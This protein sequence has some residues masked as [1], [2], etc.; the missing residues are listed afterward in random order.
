MRDN[1]K[2][3]A[4]AKSFQKMS[5][6]GAME[7][8]AGLTKNISNRIADISLDRDREK[9]VIYGSDSGKD[10]TPG[11]HRRQQ[12]MYGSRINDE[13][14]RLDALLQN[15]S[16]NRKAVTG[17]GAY[18]SEEKT[19]PIDK[20]GSEDALANAADEPELKG[21]PDL[22][23]AVTDMKSVPEEGTFEAGH[24]K[25]FGIIGEQN[26]K[27]VGDSLRRKARESYVGYEKAGK[28]KTRDKKP[29]NEVRLMEEHS[30]LIVGDKPSAFAEESVSKK[31]I[32]KEKTLA[33]IDHDE[34]K[35]TDITDDRTG[36][37]KRLVKRNAAVSFQKPEQKRGSGDTFGFIAS[38]EDRPIARLM[39]DDEAGEIPA[40]KGVQGLDA[41]RDKLA[42][43]RKHFQTATLL[44]S[45]T[46]V[47]RQEIKESDDNPATEAAVDAEHTAE[48]AVYI[49]KNSV[50][51]FLHHGDAVT[52]ADLSPK[53]SHKIYFDDE[54]ILPDAMTVLE[55]APK[56][57]GTLYESYARKGSKLYEKSALQGKLKES[58]QKPKGMVKDEPVKIT[59]SEQAKVAQ[60]KRIKKSYAN[61]LREQA[62]TGRQVSNT[63][64][65]AAEFGAK[66]IRGTAGKM[67]D[68]ALS[69]MKR[70]P[71]VIAALIAVMLFGVVIANCFGFFG[72][73]LG[74]AGQIFMGST[75]LSSD[76]DIKNAD[77]L[78]ESYE[79]EL[80]KQVDNIESDY[81]GYDEYRYQVD[82]ISHDAYA[83]ASYLTAMY[84]NYKFDDI[85]DEL[86]TLFREQYVLTINEI[87]EKR[88]RT[89]DNGDGTTSEEEYNWYVLEVTLTNKGMDSIAQ[90]RLNDKQL[91]LYK[92]YQSSLGNR[93]YLFGDAITAGN[94]AAGGMSYDIP[95]EALA[96]EGFARMIE[97]GEKYLGRAYVWGGST[98]QSGFDCSG[99][100]SWVV[101]HSGNG[102]DVGRSTAEGLRNRCTYVSQSE[103]KPG[104]LIF[105]EKTYNTAGASH[106]GIYVGNGM[107]MHC[108]N[109]IQYTSINSN[110]WQSHFL[111][112]GRL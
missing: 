72:T 54:V 107:M 50:G 6:D 56:S 112:F 66:A 70:H 9:N 64:S 74:E 24:R 69:F 84:G 65:K 108:G 58:G 92:T 88:T 53:K 78:Y 8:S 102:W 34:E 2:L 14:A 77:T 37:K 104:D 7:V 22:G 98:P 63:V 38:S 18:T 17:V 81:P 31:R 99:F 60:K 83:L 82:E 57:K 47:I 52:P 4:K 76:D 85:K 12:Q 19:V 27:V 109:P 45:T 39:F 10:K 5:R 46:D 51:D 100:V 40:D 87:V 95:P 21:I 80:Q 29:E 91:S 26:A 3:E 97:E 94:P 89:V 96:D 55:R 101:N 44:S 71:G 30:S 106:V 86:L 32:R 13:E 41:S 73:M 68:V 20:A 103:A 43:K 62:R 11:D 110:Y 16:G 105:F 35:L 15:V 36:Y 33:E 42:K 1:V 111:A 49:V 48:N 67:K 25:K 28:E 75:Y 59:V 93:S 61:A 90:E 23:T 79:E